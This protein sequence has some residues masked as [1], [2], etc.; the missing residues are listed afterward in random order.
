MAIF[1]KSLDIFGF[2]SFAERTHIEFAD[3]ITALIGPNGCG[4]SNI[5]DAIKWVLAESRARALRASSMEDVIFNGTERRSALNVAEVTLTIMNEDGKL[6]L[7][8][9][10][11]AIKRRLYRSGEGEYFING[12]LSGAREVRQ[13]FMDTGIGKSAYSVMEQGKIDQILSSKPEDR[14]YLFEEAAGISRSKEECRETER[15]LERTL[16]NMG[17][18]E[19]SLAE[20]K[21]QH[22]ALQVQAERTK[23]WRGIK[24]NIFECE[25]DAALLKLKDFV[26][27]K[28]RVEA[29]LKDA[30]EK[31]EA[32]KGEI[33]K[34][35][36]EL[37]ENKDAVDAMQREVSAK[38]ADIIG[39]QKEKVGKQEILRQ[40]AVRAQEAAEKIGQ[41]EARRRAITEEVE[42]LTEEIDEEG[43]SL[44]EKEKQLRDAKRNIESFEKTIEETSD[45][46]SS[47]DIAVQKAGEEVK[48]LNSEAQKIARE[49]AAITEDI[50][51]EMEEHLKG[52][53]FSAAAL[54]KSKEELEKSIASL[55]V[56]AA[57]RK[58]VFGDAVNNGNAK[59]ALDAL[60]AFSE[61]ERLA[62]DVEEKVKG[63]IA[64][65]PAFIAEFLS[66]EGIITKKRSVD[67][68][69]LLNTSKIEAVRERASSLRE[70]NVALVEKIDGYRETLSKLKVNEAKMT[71]QKSASE[72]KVALL[73]RTLSS[74][75]VSLLGVDSE[76]SSETEKSDDIAQ[77]M[78]G[79][80]EE[81]T[82]IER[83]GI[84]IADELKELDKKIAQ[85]SG[86][87]AG[88]EA[89]L[90]SKRAEEAALQSQCE[91]L[92]LTM[93]TSD[94]EIR[95]LKQNFQDT[96]SRDL[97]ADEERM[98]KITESSVV[99]RTRLAN[100][101]EELRSLG[102][103]N[104]MAVEEFAEAK[105]RYDRLKAGYDDLNTSMENLKRVSEE[106]RAKASETFLDTYNKIKRNFHNMFRRLFG[107][108][109]AEL[110]L[111]DPDNVLTSGIDIFA[112]PPG[113]KLE[114]ITLLSGGEKTM[115]AVA[116]LFAT[117][118]VRPSPF[119]LLDEID[120]ALDDRNVTCFASTLRS[121]SKLSQYI[122]I[123]HNRHTIVGT[124]RTMIGIT[125]QE[126]GVSNVLSYPIDP[127]IQ[128]AEY[129]EDGDFVEEDVEKENVTL[130]ERPPARGRK[131]L[132]PNGD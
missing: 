94:T 20:A 10:E 5:V 117:Y 126:S 96:H 36:S 67:S 46:M 84:R 69:M 17:Q 57:G 28:A 18:L 12:H 53:S 91:K 34:I 89:E 121:F 97:M 109:R 4:K 38:Q 2:K 90:K 63:Y 35:E 9:A 103:V 107:G 74:Q 127:S 123:T 25:R 106:I 112:Q 6:P 102:Q 24:D 27:T 80:K 47:N 31:Q 132:I 130:P 122:V 1:L 13:L 30:K 105:D 32:A 19:V 113:K 125:M 86:D 50:V 99:I 128:V 23:K 81:L 43:A 110:R 7:E 52:S 104:H 61:V 11:I 73:R 8:A 42:S 45:K 48:E 111:S 65:S 44:Y 129:E 66:P 118:Q 14:R 3:G 78:E 115:T 76:L 62:L 75:R 56:Y 60:G 71:A 68:K 124:A 40:Y 116:L 37:I 85:N 59:M 54:A 55:K 51:K 83:K 100:L 88:K 72:D 21:K 64:L 108:G 95:V 92:S 82:D 26:Q 22:D 101:K 131:D 79:I 119:C 70:A 49:L 39:L 33:Q 16:V 41:L 15:E 114:N 93:A 58:A 98:Y 29:E 120:A 77:E 87:M